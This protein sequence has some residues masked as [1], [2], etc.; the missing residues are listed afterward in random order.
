MT[1]GSHSRRGLTLPKIVFL[2]AILA[3]IVALGA[4]RLLGSEVSARR[5]ALT[6]Q[7]RTLQGQVERYRGRYGTPRLVT[8][9]WRDF[10]TKGFFRIPPRNPLNDSNLV[11]AAVGPGVGWVWRAGDDG[12]RHLFATDET[13]LA[14]FVPDPDDLKHL[15]DD[16]GDDEADD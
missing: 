3:V 15:A 4:S 1:L 14:E 8:D 7:L 5:T 11:A 16:S 12:Q 10:V 9:Q 2:V 6:T 13:C